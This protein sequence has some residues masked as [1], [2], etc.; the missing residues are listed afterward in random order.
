MSSQA[1]L[2]RAAGRHTTPVMERLPRLAQS[3]IKYAILIAMTVVTIYPIVWMI[4]GSL[5]DDYQFYNNIW[6]PPAVVHVEN[7]VT[8]WTR[9]GLGVKYFNSLLNTVLFLVLLIPIASCAAYVCA[10]VPKS[11]LPIRDLIYLFL[12]IGIVIPRGVLA[13]PVYQVIV[14]L[15]IN[16][17]RMS[18]IL[19]YIAQ[20]LSFSIFLLRSFYISLPKGLEEAALI[21]GCN[22]FQSFLY[23]MTPLTMPGIITVAIFGGL[24]VWNEYFLASI[25]IRSTELQTLPLGM[26]IFVDSHNVYYPELFAALAITSVPVIM[27][28]LLAQRRFMSG[29][30]AGAMK[31]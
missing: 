28:F 23:V 26:A 17:T 12:L 27:V 21:D 24:N 20:F 31:G 25:F 30:T 1:A 4:F 18:L 8:A 2:S 10:R 19:V 16:G 6:G 11:K 7:Y 5:K 14:A 3:A 15:G 13:I 22:R 29:L 9:A